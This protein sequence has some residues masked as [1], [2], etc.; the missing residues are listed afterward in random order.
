MVMSLIGV[1]SEEGKFF[2]AR[3][4]GEITVDESGMPQPEL[5]SGGWLKFGEIPITQGGDWSVCFFGSGETG[6]YVNETAFPQ[7]PLRP[8][9]EYI[10]P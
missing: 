8:Y 10:L 3:F 6:S 5:R 1:L 4:N 7:V 9:D 2:F